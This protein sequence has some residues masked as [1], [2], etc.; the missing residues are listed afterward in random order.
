MI[1]YYFISGLHLY[2]E[3]RKSIT[4]GH[5]RFILTYQSL[6][7]NPIIKLIWFRLVDL[8]VTVPS[9]IIFMLYSKILLVYLAI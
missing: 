9:Q 5:A 2:E 6:T 3:T 7:K 4:H 8:G 1:S